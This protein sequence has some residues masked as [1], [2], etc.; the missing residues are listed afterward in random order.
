MHESVKAREIE[1]EIR[2]KASLKGLGPIKKVVLRAGKASG[3]APEE[4]SHI[5]REHMK[6]ETFEIIEENAALKCTGCGHIISEQEKTLKCPA[7]GGIENKIIAGMG[8][9]VVEVE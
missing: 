4:L 9:E 6:I 3:E 1:K 8:F 5:L 7:C 2:R